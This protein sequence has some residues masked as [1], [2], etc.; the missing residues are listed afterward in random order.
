MCTLAATE[1]MVFVESF[2]VPFTIVFIKMSVVT[3]FK[4]DVTISGK[5]ITIEDFDEV[6]RLTTAIIID[7]CT[8]IKWGSIGAVLAH[9]R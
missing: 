3:T 8:S 5:V 4:P 7:Y 1:Q 2:G 6:S 9:R